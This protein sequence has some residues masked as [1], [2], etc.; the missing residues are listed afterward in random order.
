MSLYRKIKLNFL[1]SVLLLISIISLPNILHAN[2]STS[3]R[4]ATQALGFSAG[5]VSGS[6]I[7]YRRY[8]GEYFLQGT[9]VGFVKNGVNDAYVN[10]AFSGGKYLHKL[11]ASGIIPPLGLK[12]M[13]GVDLVMERRSVVE[14]KLPDGSATNSSNN[15]D[16]A[17][18]G[19][20]VGLDIGNPGRAGLSLWLAV[21]YVFAY[22]GIIAPEFKWFAAR[23]A[24]GILYGW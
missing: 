2:E 6:G 24:A 16:K 20:G 21:S 10:T 22:D 15:Y 13:G 11:N 12:V 7:T 23:P 17:Y 8:F 5:W 1:R 18:Y 19:A 9:V 3:H 14:T 4:N